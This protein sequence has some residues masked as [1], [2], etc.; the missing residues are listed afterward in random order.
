MTSKT[1]SANLQDRFADKCEP[2]PWIGCVIWTGA[3][4]ADGRYGTMRF[5]DKNH[6][7]H[8]I[9]WEIKHGPVPDGMNVLHK[10]DCGLCVNAD[11]LFIGTQAENVADMI[12]KGRKNIG[13]SGLPGIPKNQGEKN[14]AARL[15]AATVFGIRKQYEIVKNKAELAR[16]FGMSESQVR[17]IVT[18]Q[19][20]RH[21]GL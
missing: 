5:G 11:H 16:V 8:H 9:A 13:R 2:V 6:Q 3:T 17:R 10:C 15:N 7:A 19:S 14:S 1:T 20:W 18:G 4:N 21:L 12:R